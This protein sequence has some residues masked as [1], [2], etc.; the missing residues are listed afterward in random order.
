MFIRYYRVLNK[1]Y[2]NRVSLTE[3]RLSFKN[4]HYLEQKL[5]YQ[6]GK[7]LDPVDYIV[8]AQET[9]IISKIGFALSRRPYLHRA[10]LVIC[11][12]SSSETVCVLIFLEILEGRILHNFMFCFILIINV[13]E[14][15]PSKL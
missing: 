3:K 8:S 7:D 9:C 13:T 6:W 14:I 12:Y 11:P 1:P 10:Y 2:V 5:C 15:D 4:Y